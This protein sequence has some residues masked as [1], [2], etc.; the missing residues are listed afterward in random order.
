MFAH[1]WE[2]TDNEV[3]NRWIR[4]ARMALDQHRKQNP[5]AVKVRV[6]ERDMLFKN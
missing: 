2:M 4:V 5:N 1:A 3:R 6:S